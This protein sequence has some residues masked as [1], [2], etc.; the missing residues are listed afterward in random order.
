MT[1]KDYM[2]SENELQNKLKKLEPDKKEKQRHD[3]EVKGLPPGAVL[4]QGGDVYD[5]ADRYLGQVKTLDSGE[6]EFVAGK[7][8]EEKPEGEKTN[9]SNGD[10]HKKSSKKVT[11][12]T[13]NSNGNKKKMEKKETI[14]LSGKQDTIV[15][16]PKIEE[17][18][19]D[20]RDYKK[21][22][23]K[24]TRQLDVKE[25]SQIGIP[26]QKMGDRDNDPDSY[27]NPHGGSG[28]TKGAVP[29]VPLDKGRK[30]DILPILRKIVDKRQH[31]RIKF[32]DGGPVD[33]DLF[34]A[35]AMIQVHDALKPESQRKFKESIK[36]KLGFLKMHSFA[37]KMIGGRAEKEQSESYDIDFDQFLT[38]W[39]ESAS[40]IRKKKIILSER[41][42][43]EHKGTSP[44]KHPHP[45]VEEESDDEYHNCEEIHP[46]MS[47]KEWKRDNKDEDEDDNPVGKVEESTALQVKMALDDAGWKLGSQGSTLVRN[48]LKKTKGDAKAAIDKIMK[49]YPGLKKEEVEIGENFAVLNEALKPRDKAVIDAFYSRK[50]NLASNLLSVEGGKLTKMGMGGQEIAIWK[51]DKIV[52]N[53]KMDVK[54]TEEI[55]RYMKKS[56][57]SGVFEE[58]EIAEG[59]KKGKYTIKDENGKIL[60]TYSSGG[61][62]KKVMDDL[63]QK[64]D[65]P[66]LTVSM[67]EEVELDEGF[68]DAIVDKFKSILSIPK[69]VALMTKSILDGNVKDMETLSSNLSDKNRDK[70][71]KIFSDQLKAGKYKGQ[72]EINIIKLLAT[73]KHDSLKEEVEIDEKK[74]ATGY[75]LYHKDFSSAMQH[76]YAFAKSKGHVVDPKE[77][78]DKVATGPKKPSSG[79]TNRYSLKAGRKKVE[80]Q[81]ANLDN[82]RYELNMYIEGKDYDAFFNSALKKFGVS[83]PADLKGDQKKKFYNYVDAN[84]KGE[85]EVEENVYVNAAANSIAQEYR[86][87]SLLIKT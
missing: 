7:P 54:S 20:V 18:I 14:K 71:I 79:E 44:H 33:V 84:W 69:N 85:N 5:K 47:H 80:I 29:N 65:Y 60:G 32:P 76:A 23:I 3:K 53:A 42:L 56:I 77:I 52:I 16:A 2:I 70:M 75:E 36:N 81:V 40:S 49:D 10:N 27:G 61:K 35:S 87:K 13:N 1:I 38:E 66:E 6:R 21:D 63:M 34:S 68:I 12:G 55:V 28:H 15:V 43:K 72:G 19:F 82:K 59:W 41:A 67:V 46:N 9:N 62:A 4:K 83:S 24:R 30:G 50:G 17:S 86:A 39:S 51:N 73:L 25:S 58:V 22:F 78:D 37:L 11:N 64:G 8:K 31:E 74:S 48:I 26:G 57:P 45:P